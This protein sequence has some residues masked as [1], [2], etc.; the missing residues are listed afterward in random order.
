MFSQLPKVASLLRNWINNGQPEEE[1]IYLVVES[2]P[3]AYLYKVVKTEVVT[4]EQLR[5]FDTGKADIVLVTCVPRL[6]YDHRLLV[7]AELV[8][9]RG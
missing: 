6:I 5:L 9:I 4:Q 1:A 2:G 7:T 8:G 3:L